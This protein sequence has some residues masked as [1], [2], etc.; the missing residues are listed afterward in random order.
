MVGVVSKEF[1]ALSTF[2]AL[3]QRTA[4]L[5]IMGEELSMNTDFNSFASAYFNGTF[6]TGLTILMLPLGPFRPIFGR[7][8]AWFQRRRQ[9]KLIDIISPVLQKRMDE[10]KQDPSAASDSLDAIEWTLRLLPEWPMNAAETQ[11]LAR[12]SEELIQN[13]WASGASPGMSITNMIFQVLEDPDT[14]QILRTEAEAAVAKHGWSDRIV[15]SLVLQDSF[16][17]EVHRLLPT[18][19]SMCP[20]TPNSPPTLMFTWTMH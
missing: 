10:R 9:L 4:A 1:S 3:T 16:I 2:T 20:I 8:V 5:V 6:T 19:T 13:L 15:N 17:R 14:L 7:A 18:F 11:P 12:I